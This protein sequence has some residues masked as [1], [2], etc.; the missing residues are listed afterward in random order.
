MNKITGNE[1][2]YPK[3]AFYHPDGGLDQPNDGMS[4]RQHFAGLAMQGLVMQQLPVDRALNEA[5][6]TLVNSIAA[7]SVKMAGALISALNQ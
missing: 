4:L 5:N 2:A 3:S 7:A 6:S 1:P